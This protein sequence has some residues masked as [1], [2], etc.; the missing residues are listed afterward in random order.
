MHLAGASSILG[1][2]NMIVTII[3]IRPKGMP[4]FR[5]PLFVWSVLITSIL[6]V[7]SLPSLAA[8][9]TILLTD[10]QF[11]TTF[12]SPIGLGDPILFQHIFWFFGHPEVYILILPGFGIVSQIIPK[13]SQQRI[14]GYHAM[15]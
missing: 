5:M 9:I 1:A 7:T 15:V 14:F 10:R 11:N 4:L 2:I 6:L 13:Y 8:V 3:N 12:F